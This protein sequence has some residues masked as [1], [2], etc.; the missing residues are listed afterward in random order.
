MEALLTFFII[1]T[2]VQ[3]TSKLV[4]EGGY[5]ELPLGAKKEESNPTEQMLR[6]VN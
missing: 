6:E 2:G 1:Y 3:G 5:W 4:L